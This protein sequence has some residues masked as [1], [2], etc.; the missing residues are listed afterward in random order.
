MV[1]H[2]V[3]GL[4]VETVACCPAHQAAVHPTPWT[5]GNASVPARCIPWPADACN[6]CPAS[7]LLCPA[8]VDHGPHDKR[9]CPARVPWRR[10][11]TPPGGPA[12]SA[13]LHVPA[14]RGQGRLH[15]CA[16]LCATEALARGCRC[17]PGTRLKV[18]DSA[19]SA[20]EGV[21]REGWAALKEARWWVQ[22]LLRNPSCKQLAWPQHL[23]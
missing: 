10:C 8:E 1:K 22:A 2:T 21:R 23:C 6:D 3:A 16:C 20:G 5:L 9:A 18:V 7:F 11:R 13:L 12:A 19:G 17:A 15:A 4:V 14:G